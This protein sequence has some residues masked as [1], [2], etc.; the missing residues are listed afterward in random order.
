MTANLSPLFNVSMGGI[1]LAD[2]ERNND[3]L[4]SFGLSRRLRLIKDRTAT[5]TTPA[6]TITS[7]LI[8]L[9]LSSAD[10]YSLYNE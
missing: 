10:A 1:G 2:P 7:K 9:S 8:G 3:K 4:L 6:T 5:A